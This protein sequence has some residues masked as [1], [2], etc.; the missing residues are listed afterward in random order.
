MQA[1]KFAFAAALVATAA[2][3]QTSQPATVTAPVASPAAGGSGAGAPAAPPQ[4]TVSSAGGSAAP[5]GT[6]AASSDASA[7]TRG[8]DT[9]ATAPGGADAGAPA[10]FRSCALDSECVAVDR[11][12][13]CHNGWKEAVAAAQKDA[14]AQ[15]FTCPEANPMCPMYLVRDGR[16]PL[17]DNATHLCTMTRPEDVACGGFIRNKHSC[18]SGY[19]C[20]LSKHPDVAG[21]CVQP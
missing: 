9:A 20:Q 1:T 16:V 10:Q 11:V 2:C 13:C 19:R 15:S 5:Q 21:K 3:A 18:P 7:G 14:Y 17:C 6:S 8:T 4:A 12:G